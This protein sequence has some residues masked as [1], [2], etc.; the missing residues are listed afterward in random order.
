M[1][2]NTETNKLLNS[3]LTSILNDGVPWDVLYAEGKTEEGVFIVKVKSTL[4]NECNT[5]EEAPLSTAM[6]VIEILANIGK[7]Q[8]TKIKG[9]MTF[10]TIINTAK[11]DA[12][13]IM[14]YHCSNENKL[15]SKSEDDKSVVGTELV[16][17]GKK[18]TA[19]IVED[20]AA[21][22]SNDKSNVETK[23]IS[24][25]LKDVDSDFTP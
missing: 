17:D 1:N 19:K 25:H 23:R 24:K 14:V 11:M 3:A 18:G 16:R 4:K 7:D 6:T 2:T 5:D 9:E 22:Y 10:S 20:I 8:I 15:P 13:T 21:Y 12:G